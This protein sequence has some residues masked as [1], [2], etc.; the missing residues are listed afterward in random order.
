MHTI[1]II[2]LFALSIAASGLIS[3]FYKTISQRVTG[4]IYL[5]AANIM[6]PLPVS[7]VFLLITLVTG[8]FRFAVTYDLIFIALAAGLLLASAAFALM[9]SLRK[10]SYTA[11]IIIVNMNFY[12]PIVLS[13]IFLDESATFLQLIGIFIVTAVIVALNISP[14]GSSSN[15]IAPKDNAIGI[16]YACI[17]CLANGGMNF[18]I[19]LQQYNTPGEGMNMFYFSVYLFA[20]LWCIAALAVRIIAKKTIGLHVS[21]IKPLIVPVLFLGMCVAVCFYPQSILSG[22]NTVNASAQF[23]ITITGSLIF[24][25]LIGWIWYKEK[26]SLKGVVSVLLCMTAILFQLVSF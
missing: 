17:A 16:L 21:K 4:N 23:T 14:G 26:F 12:I 9:V 3:F 15:E 18:C 6:W 7:A 5:L 22:I 1:F 2:A 20:S 25:L 24:A 13:R 11:A 8:E 10:G 19:K